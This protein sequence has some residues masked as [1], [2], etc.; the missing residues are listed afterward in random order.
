MV[1]QHHNLLTVIRPTSGGDGPEFRLQ[2]RRRLPVHRNLAASSRALLCFLP[3]RG[4]LT[5]LLLLSLFTGVPGDV[6][7]LVPA[8]VPL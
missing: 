6:P 7:P 3:R 2:L 5:Y 4:R 8:D 1:A